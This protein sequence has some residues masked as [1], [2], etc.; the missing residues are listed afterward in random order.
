MCISEDVIPN[1]VSFLVRLV[2]RQEQ[3]INLLDFLFRVLLFRRPP[4]QEPEVTEIVNPLFSMEL[5]STHTKVLTNVNKQKQFLEWIISPI[6]ACY[7]SRS[8]NAIM[9]AFVLPYVRV[10]DVISTYLRLRDIPSESSDIQVPKDVFHTLLLLLR[11]HS[12]Q[13]RLHAL[14]ILIAFNDILHLSLSDPVLRRCLAI[15][16]IKLTP[17]RTRE[18][19]SE[20]GN[21]HAGR[22]EI[23]GS[24]STAQASYYLI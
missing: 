23:T 10:I 2:S 15:E 11:S 24:S 22:E 1:L 12:H 21:L 13:I 3:P 6:K 9:A 17:Q 5:A 20:V 8:E 18:F 14:R 4:L 7:G 16:R 19:I